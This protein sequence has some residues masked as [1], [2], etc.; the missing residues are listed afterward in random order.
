MQGKPRIRLEPGPGMHAYRVLAAV[1]LL[2]QPIRELRKTLDDPDFV[3]DR[4][5]SVSDI[6][7][8]IVGVDSQRVIL[9]PTCLWL[10]SAAGF[11]RPV[12]FAE[13]MSSVQTMW[14]AA[15]QKDSPLATAI[16]EHE[17]SVTARPSD[18]SA[19]LAAAKNVR[20][21]LG[22]DEDLL[23]LVAVSL[24]AALE[25][26]TVAPPEAAVPAEGLDDPTPPAEASKREIAKW[27]LQAVRGSSG[28]KFSKDV[29]SAYKDCCAISGLALPRIPGSLNSAL[30]AAHILPWARYDLNDV[31]NGLCLNKLCHWAFDNAVIRVDFESGSGMYI[32]SVPDAVKACAIDAGFA[33]SHFQAFEGPISRERLP[34]SRAH[35]PSPVYLA[36]LNRQLFAA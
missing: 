18:H 29:R 7:V 25:E 17:R 22:G 34:A 16:R 13:R 1:L 32:V 3:R 12:D 8:D 35:W 9:R 4:G 31:S 30:D 26:P 5:F 15:A 21:I 23:P 20:K 27:R 19:M 28:R 36:E 11:V 2:P 14:D 10:T 6:D 33:I 24:G